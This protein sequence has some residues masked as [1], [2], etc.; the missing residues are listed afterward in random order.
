MGFLHP[1]AHR[2]PLPTVAQHC[3]SWPSCPC[4][5]VDNLPLA[6]YSSGGILPTPG[7]L[8]GATDLPGASGIL[9]GTIPGAAAS[10]RRPT[11]PVLPASFPRVRVRAVSSPLARF[12]FRA[13][14]ATDLPGASG[15]LPTAALPAVGGLL[16]TSTGLLSVDLGVGNTVGATATVGGATIPVGVPISA[17]VSVSVD[18][19][20]HL[21]GV[22]GGATLPVASVLRPAYRLCLGPRSMGRHPHTRP[23]YHP[24]LLA[25]GSVTARDGTLQ[26]SFDFSSDSGA[27][28]RLGAAGDA[29]EAPSAGRDGANGGS[30][31][32]G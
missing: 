15:I 29:S 13:A 12:P 27:V 21:G 8:P 24:S 32:G 17:P 1:T 3:P 22:I 25:P 5:N 16:L 26:S 28:D 6:N 19:S 2:G 11:C 7:I 18:L 20:A 14:G 9:S 31:W 30:G 4:A 10:S 23:K